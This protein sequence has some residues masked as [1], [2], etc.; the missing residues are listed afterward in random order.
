MLVVEYWFA[1]KEHF[2]TKNVESHLPA[3]NTMLIFLVPVCSPLFLEEKKNAQLGYQNKKMLNLPAP[4][5]PGY[6]MSMSVG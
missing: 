4:S 5:Q 2:E 1:S 6:Q 3:V